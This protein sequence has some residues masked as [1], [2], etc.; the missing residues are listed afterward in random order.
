MRATRS[1]SSAGERAGG[2]RTVIRR[3]HDWKGL[4]PE[5]CGASAAFGNF[6]GVHLG[7]RKVIEPAKAA[8]AR[9]GAPT[10]VISFE[11]HPRRWFQP[12]AAP[13][14]VMSLDQQSRA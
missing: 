2:G 3:V 1:P 8:A 14:Q 13:F 12:N 6:D 7:H 11:P 4:R 5:D 10:A 9:L